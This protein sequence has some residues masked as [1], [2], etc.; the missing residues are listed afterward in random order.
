VNREAIKASP[1]ECEAKSDILYIEQVRYH[2]IYI[3]A[4]PQ[5]R[6]TIYNLQTTNVKVVPIQDIKTRWSSTFLVLRR[7]KRRRTIFSLFCTEYDCGG[8]AT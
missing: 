4:S 1:R 3:N 5:R 6:E 7:A 2:A 8:D